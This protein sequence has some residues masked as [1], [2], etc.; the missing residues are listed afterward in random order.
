VFSTDS[1]VTVGTG[2]FLGGGVLLCWWFTWGSWDELRRDW[3]DF[4][5]AANHA[6]ANEKEREAFARPTACCR[7]RVP[8]N[9]RRLYRAVRSDHADVPVS[10]WV[11]RCECGESTS[12]NAT[13]KGRRLEPASAA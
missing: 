8:L 7:C 9:L 4:R 5:K 11:Y 6:R 12:Y 10:G 2:L 13:G 3:Q 1:F